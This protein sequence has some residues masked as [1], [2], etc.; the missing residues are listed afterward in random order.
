MNYGL[1]INGIIDTVSDK[2]FPGAVKI[3]DSVSIDW[4]YNGTTFTGP[5]P[6]LKEVNNHA[7]YLIMAATNSKDR[8]QSDERISA[9]AREATALLQLRVLNG[10]WTT[11]QE[12]RAAEL[13][14]ISSYIAAVIAASNVL[15]VMEPIPNDYKNKTKWP[16]AGDT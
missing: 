15:N 6:T 14:A 7:Q 4:T 2:D 5:T 9:G 10:S 16:D 13:T 8:G 3:P 12:T 11:E 1:I